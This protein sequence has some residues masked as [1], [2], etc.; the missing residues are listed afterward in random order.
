MGR[1]NTGV[2]EMNPECVVKNGKQLI[3]PVCSN[4]S[5]VAQ[6]VQLN[7]KG[8]TFLGLDWLNEN[9]DVYICSSC[10]YLYWFAEA[11]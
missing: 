6:K 9:A 8:L 2:D 10:G 1:R 3:C 11:R 7:T 5:F 4:N